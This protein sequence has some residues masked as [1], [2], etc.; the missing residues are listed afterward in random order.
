[1]DE[2][3]LL[4]MRH[5]I[6]GSILIIKGRRVEF[7]VSIPW[8]VKRCDFPRI[9]QKLEDIKKKLELDG[10][11]IWDKDVS[12]SEKVYTIMEQLVD[13]MNTEEQK[14]RQTYQTIKDAGQL[15]IAVSGVWK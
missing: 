15:F 6:P 8:E 12:T 2:L 5:S 4:P 11:P 13:T 10:Y 14:W 9:E 1:M 7:P 3:R